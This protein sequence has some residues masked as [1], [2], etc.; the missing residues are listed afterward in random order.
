MSKMI[1]TQLSTIRLFSN[2]IKNVKPSDK[3]IARNVL[4]HDYK[5]DLGVINVLDGTFSL[6]FE[7]D[8]PLA[9]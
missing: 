1:N 2:K 9:V 5:C 4:L 6:C 7:D 8:I 3:I